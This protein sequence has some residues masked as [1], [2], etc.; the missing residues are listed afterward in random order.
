MFP[1]LVHISIYLSISLY[2]YMRVSVWFSCLFLYPQN[3][4]NGSIV[5]ELASK[6]IQ[7]ASSSPRVWTFSAHL[8]AEAS[9]GP[10]GAIAVTGGWISNYGFCCLPHAYSTSCLPHVGEF[11][12]ALIFAHAK[13][14]RMMFPIETLPS[15]DPDILQPHLVEHWLSP[16]VVPQSGGAPASNCDGQQRLGAVLATDFFFSFK[17]ALI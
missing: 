1:N 4:Q 9:F 12:Y 15:I 13:M 11:Q 2:I 6:D 7:I 5:R 17:D 3:S 10:L 8:A 14:W 16:P